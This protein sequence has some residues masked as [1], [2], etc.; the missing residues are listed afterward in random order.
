LAKQAMQT[1]GTATTVLNAANEV[2]VQAF[3]DKTIRFTDIAITVEHTLG[4]C[5]VTQA[6]SLE[7]IIRTDMFAREVAHEFVNAT[8]K[9]TGAS[10]TS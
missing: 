10:V 2:A 7:T 6:D 3:L 8:G 5:A 9:R 1:G 4:H